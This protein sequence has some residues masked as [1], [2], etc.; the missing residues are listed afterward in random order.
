MTETIDLQERREELALAVLEGE[1]GA[2][3]ELQKVEKEIEERQR[4]AER[5]SLAETA[6]RK[7]EQRLAEEEALRKQEEA[8]QEYLRLLGERIQA[9]EG[10]EGLLN[11][12][13]AAL[14]RHKQLG[15][16]A[17]QAAARWGRPGKHLRDP[18][19]TIAMI[20]DFFGSI[21]PNDFIRRSGRRVRSV[22][23]RERRIL[24]AVKHPR[25]TEPAPAKAPPREEEPKTFI[26]SPL[27]TCIE[28]ETDRFL[29]FDDAATRAR[30]IAEAEASNRA[31]FG[32]GRQHEVTGYQADKLKL[33]G[34]GQFLTRINEKGE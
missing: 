3:A 14:E 31:V 8:K 12:M 5:A 33:Q 17:D 19:P 21:Y 6:R 34:F 2:K 22:A 11:N 32:G 28:V 10:I 29:C 7:R 25:A 1:K 23:E 15:V 16:D 20:H 9:S 27:N 30:K 18:A 13:M 24:E 26:F 4:E